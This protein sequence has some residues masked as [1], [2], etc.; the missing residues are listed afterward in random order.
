MS[1]AKVFI[2]MAPKRDKKCCSNCI[3]FMLWGVGSGIC[4]R[5]GKDKYQTNSCKHFK[6]KNEK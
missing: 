5:T 6:N 1:D 2:D 4:H 3:D